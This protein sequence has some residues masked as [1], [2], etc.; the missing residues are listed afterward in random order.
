MSQKKLNV[1]VTWN[2]DFKRWDTISTLEV[3]DMVRVS[4]L[5]ILPSLLE[6]RV[7]ACGLIKQLMEHYQ[8]ME[9]SARVQEVR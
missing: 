1:D 9:S 3:G 5:Y 4:A 6:D 2:E 7:A 8:R